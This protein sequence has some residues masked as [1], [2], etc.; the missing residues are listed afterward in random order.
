MREPN[1]FSKS[2]SADLDK[3]NYPCTDGIMKLRANADLLKIWII[4]HVTFRNS[5]QTRKHALML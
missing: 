3:K 4:H 1:S 2:A 5:T